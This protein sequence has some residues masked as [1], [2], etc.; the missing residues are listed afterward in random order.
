MLALICGSG[1]LPR[2]VAAAH[3][4]RPVVCALEGFEPE[5]LTPD[6]PFRLE[7]L[8]SLF[9]KLAAKGVT[10]VCFCG[11]IDRP[12]IDPEAIDLSTQP[13]VP[14]FMQGLALG[15]DGALRVVMEIFEDAGFAV[16]AA[17]KAAPALL[18]PPGVL[19]A[20][21]PDEFVQADLP[22]AEA[23]LARMGD[24]DLG[25]SCVLHDGEVV[26][27][28]DEAG[29]DAM[30]AKLHRAPREEGS[31]PLGRALDAAGDL[32]GAAAGWLSGQ[33]EPP[34]GFLYKG[35]KPGQDRRADLPVI[36]PGTARGIIASGLAGIVIE[37]GGVMLLHREETVAMLDKAGRF[38]WVREQGA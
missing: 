33:G 7:T 13:L 28:E 17:H 19:T 21:A 38:I 2:A 5:G 12:S 11:R 1:D 4:P 27:R 9:P 16:L 18:P 34:Q 25:Q 3:R 23:T 26:L 20:R 29:T 31:A 22:L 24:E 35:P 14:R 15:D 10:R 32:I 37:A 30:L 8:G 6:I 36:G